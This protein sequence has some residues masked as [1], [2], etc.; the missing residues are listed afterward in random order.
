MPNAWGRWRLPA[1]WLAAALVPASAWAGGPLYVGGTA[2]NAAAQGHAMVWDT[3]NPVA[4]RTPSAGSLGKLSNAQAVMRVQQLFQFWQDVPTANI[5]YQNAGAIQATGGYTGGAIDSAATFNAVDGSCQKGAQSPIIF[6]ATGSVMSELG[7]D[8]SIIG[9][10][11]ACQLDAGGHILSAEVAMNGAWIDGNA[12]NGELRD[13]EFNEAFVHEFGHFSGLD[14]AQINVDVLLQPQG[15][16]DSAELAGLP[17]MFPFAQCQARVDAGLAM[18]SPDDMAWISMLYPETVNNPPTQIPFSSQYGIIS[19]SVFFHDGSTLAQGVNVIA[20]SAAN[21]K[22]VAMSVVSGYLFSG[23]PGQT[24]SGDNTGDGGLG[25]HDPLLIGSY[26]I[27]VLAGSYDI[28]I[29]SIV[30]DF[31]GGSSVGPLFFPIAAPGDAPALRSQSIA[32]G[33][34]KTGMNFTCHDSFSRFDQ[35]EPQ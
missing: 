5:R 30:A 20:R 26:D 33:A 13:N 19:G 2:V 4:Y 35:F 1:A 14:H 24:V 12:A 6:D 10:A 8:P 25:S 17:V 18:L 21:P 31:A 23:N 3:T 29:E 32:A 28:S 9:F 11:G 15:N 7:L 27:P 34:H 16:C 22:G